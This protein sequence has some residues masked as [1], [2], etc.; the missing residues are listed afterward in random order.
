MDPEF[1]E[2]RNPTFL[3]LTTAILCHALRCWKMG[4]FID[5]VHFTRS[6]SRGKPPLIRVRGG[7]PLIG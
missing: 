2:K 1:L 7:N 3:C 4:L 5:E 6:N